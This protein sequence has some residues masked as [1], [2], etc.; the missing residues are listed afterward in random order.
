MYGVAGHHVLDV[1]LGM[2]LAVW[3]GMVYG[4]VYSANR[5]TAPGSFYKP[6]KWRG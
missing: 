4:V 1:E 2:V 3:R 6:A 5:F